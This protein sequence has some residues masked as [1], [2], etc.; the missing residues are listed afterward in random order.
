[1]SKQLTDNQFVQYYRQLMLPQ[2]EE[3]GQHALLLQHVLIIGAGGLGT[4]V[5]QQLTG[6]GIGHI[7]LVDDDKVETSNLPR[8]IL[9][10]PP[11]VGQLKVNQVKNR[12]NQ[13][14][15]DTTVYV[16]PKRFDSVTSEL[17]IKYNPALE[18]VVNNRRLIVLDCSD[19][20]PTR[21]A[22][23]RWCVNNKLTLVSAAI[24][25]YAGQLLLVD[26]EQLAETGCYRCIFNEQ[27][28]TQGC[29]SMGVLGPAVGVMASM[30][31]MLTLNYL[32]KTPSP[33]HLHLFDGLNLSWRKL[34]RKR[35]PSCPVCQHV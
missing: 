10:G 22:V 3:S 2:V 29:E 25:A 33:A 34:Q 23:N 12:L 21:Q 6:A 27:H 28:S 24:S 20:M 9:F 32:L 5:A 13:Q 35:D 26:M 14:N 15:N 30:Q 17:L 7:H 4:H 1:M 8:Q 18:A 31:C 16:Y 19:N 11:D